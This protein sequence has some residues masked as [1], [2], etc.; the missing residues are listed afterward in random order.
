MISTGTTV[1]GHWRMAICV[2]RPARAATGARR[3]NAWVSHWVHWVHRVQRSSIVVAS[4]ATI[5]AVSF[6]TFHLE[7]SKLSGTLGLINLSA[8]AHWRWA[9]G[10]GKLVGKHSLLAKVVVVVCAAHVCILGNA[11]FAGFPAYKRTAHGTGHDTRCNDEDCSRKHDPATPLYVRHEQQNV[12][13]EGQK[14]D[15]QSRDGEDE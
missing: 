7:C 3:T 9:V 10:P 13:Q 5:L 4:S 6:L 11:L 15:Q 8:A 14:S 2:A 12:D 1:H